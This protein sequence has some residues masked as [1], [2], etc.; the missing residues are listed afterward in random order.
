MIGNGPSNRF[1]DNSI[2]GFKVGFNITEFDVDV[3]YASDEKVIRRFKDNPKLHILK[4]PFM[5]HKRG[6]NV[7]WNTGHNAYNHLKEQGY[8]EFDLFGFDLLWSDVWDSS[9]DKTFN[10]DGWVKSAKKANLNGEW[11]QYWN[12]LIDVPTTIHVPS[13]SKMP[14]KNDFVRLC[15]YE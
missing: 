9:T 12:E 10:K 8:T 11:I 5:K 15:E 6:I 7:A 3:I 2:E 14:F 4:K 1:Y 13:G